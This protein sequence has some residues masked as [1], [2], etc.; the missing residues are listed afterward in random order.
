MGLLNDINRNL[1][2]ANNTVNSAKSTV[3]KIKQ[4][5]EYTHSDRYQE[6]LA[7]VKRLESKAD[8]WMVLA[9][10]ALIICLVMLIVTIVFCVRG[11]DVIL[12]L[13]GLR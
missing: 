7:E 9:G 11:N 2:A 4:G 6:D 5:Y 13:V 8:R 3:G 10:I 1:M 12:R